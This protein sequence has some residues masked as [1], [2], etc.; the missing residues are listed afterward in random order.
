M[1]EYIQFAKWVELHCGWPLGALFAMHYGWPVFAFLRAL[2]FALSCEVSWRASWNYACSIG[3]HQ[4][5]YRDPLYEVP[6]II[7]FVLIF[8]SAIIMLS[9][10][11]CQ[12]LI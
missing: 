3:D 6:A 7:I 4:N 11:I 10:L 2:I 5:I 12:A 9:G 1:V 8:V